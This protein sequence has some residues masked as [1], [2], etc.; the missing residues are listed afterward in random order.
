[1]SDAS[2]HEMS[3]A[4]HHDLDKLA[5]WKV[6]LDADHGAGTFPACAIFLV[7][8]E[9]RHSH[10]IFRRYRTA[11]EELGGGFHHLVIFGQHGISTT[12]LSFLEQLGLEQLGLEQAGQEPDSVPLLAIAPMAANP[13]R[14]YYIALP[15]G[16]RDGGLDESQ[17][18]GRVLQRIHSA[19]SGEEPLSLDGLDGVMLG[20]FRA[21][22]LDDAVAGVYTALGGQ[23]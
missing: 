5:R 20:G 17:A 7:S 21:G 15:K 11:F 3:H 4:D 12:Q 13:G 10:D 18:W 1:M 19:A 22:S 23:G 16:D 9:A 14:A 6:G 2:A 8:P